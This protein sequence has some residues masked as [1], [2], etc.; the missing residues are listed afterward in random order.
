MGGERRWSVNSFTLLWQKILNSSLWVQESKETRLVWI[1]LLAMKDKAGKVYSS[2]V[3]LA[4]RAKVTPDECRE[5][6]AIL[7]SPDPNDTSKVEEGRRIREIPG[8]WEVVNH[9]LYRFSTEEKREFWRATK[10]EERAKKSTAGMTPAQRAAYDKGVKA[11]T[12]RKR[13]SK[14]DAEINGRQD[15]VISLLEKSKGDSDYLPTEPEGIP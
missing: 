15:Q 7:L 14:H 2:A 9:D 4:D 13:I 6:L 3:G 1:T 8:G 11:V 5:S 10:A 12:K